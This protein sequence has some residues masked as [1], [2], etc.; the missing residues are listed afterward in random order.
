EEGRPYD[1]V[2][3]LEPSSPFATAEHLDRAVEVWATHGASLVVGMR[4]VTVA[5]RFVGPLRDDGRADRVISK[6]AG[7][8][9]RRQEVEQEY[10]MNGA[11]YLV[12]WASMRR[13]GRIYG[14]P[15]RTWGL[16]MDEAHSADVESPFDLAFARYLVDS[17]VLDTSPWRP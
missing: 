6:F 12:D 5:S 4:A 1:A 13:T 11:L 10:T 14:D 2:M 17:G 8:A 9:T 7:G 16:V 3:L 15:E